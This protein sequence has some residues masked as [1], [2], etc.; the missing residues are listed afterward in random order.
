MNLLDALDTITAI[1]RRALAGIDFEKRMSGEVVLR[2]RI[3]NGGIQWHKIDIANVRVEPN[4][5]K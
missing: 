4:Q 5:T 3:Q 2:V 1:V